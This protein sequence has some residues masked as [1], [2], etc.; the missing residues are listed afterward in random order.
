MPSDKGG[1]FVKRDFTIGFA[2]AEVGVCVLS[3]LLRDLWWLMRFSFGRSENVF[4]RKIYARY[5]DWILI[6]HD[7]GFGTLVF[8]KKF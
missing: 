2:I 5:T 1:Y 6:A 4:L 3:M 8:V 7:V